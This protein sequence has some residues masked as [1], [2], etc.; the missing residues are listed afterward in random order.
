MCWKRFI[1][2]DDCAISRHYETNLIGSNDSAWNRFS[3]VRLKWEW[4]CGY[5]CTNC[6]GTQHL[7]RA[8]CLL[9]YLCTL[10]LRGRH[11]QINVRQ[12][13]INT[14]HSNGH[15]NRRTCY[16]DAWWTVNYNFM[17]TIIS[18]KCTPRLRV[19]VYCWTWSHKYREWP[20][21]KHMN[22]ARTCAAKT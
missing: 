1:G 10:Y 14:L 18:I 9:V 3:V 5:L 22:W 2:A 20:T 19:T 11:I 16:E 8:T 15:S 12:T 21:N 17:F 6:D 7:N 13:E 4:L